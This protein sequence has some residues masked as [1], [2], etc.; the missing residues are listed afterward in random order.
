MLVTLLRSHLSAEV[1]RNYI[2]LFCCFFGYTFITELEDSDITRYLDNFHLIHGEIQ[3]GHSFID[4]LKRIYVVD[5]YTE[6][7]NPIVTYLVALFT[8][9][10]RLLMLIY[11]AFFGFYYSYNISWVL[12][13]YSLKSFGIDRGQPLYLL[14]LFFLAI[15]VWEMNGIRMWLGIN[16]FIYYAI[17]HFFNKKSI[18]YLFFVPLLYHSSF[19]ILCPVVVIV[20]KFLVNLKDTK[21]LLLIYVLLLLVFYSGYKMQIV[22]IDLGSSSNALQGKIDGYNQD[23]TYFNELVDDSFQGSWFIVMRSQ[24]KV[25]LMVIIK[26]QFI[27]SIYK[28]RRNMSFIQFEKFLL[29]LGCFSYLVALHPAPS[30]QRYASISDTFLIAYLIFI[31]MSDKE[32]L[33][34]F[35]NIYVFGTIKF[36]I[37]FNLVIEIR[38]GFDVLNY[39]L[40]L[41]NPFTIAYFGNDTPLIEFYHAIFGKFAG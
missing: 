20:Y 7:F 4:Q 28:R 21:L 32:N 18:L 29:I 16:A 9:D 10:Q 3:F 8:D 31:L 41:G 33:E 6:P 19:M 2:F 13:I 14:L 11:G 1:K 37:L 30:A 12:G 17:R 36:F 15:P 40:F 34:L 26:I 24:F 25:L 35:R 27:I 38:N 23:E 5:N 22:N 39:A